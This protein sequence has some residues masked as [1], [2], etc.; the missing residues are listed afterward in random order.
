MWLKIDKS[1]TNYEYD[2]YMCCTYV[3]HKPS[4][5][6][7]GDDASKLDILLD[8]LIYNEKGCAVIMGDLNCR[9]GI[10]HD[11]IDELITDKYV[12]LIYSERKQAYNERQDIR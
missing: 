7:R 11:Y 2:V 5:R 10:E 1:L 8:I 4:C 6:F 3:S 9:T 12:I